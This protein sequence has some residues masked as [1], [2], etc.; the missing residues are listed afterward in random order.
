M[1]KSRSETRI[2][3]V[4]EAELLISFSHRKSGGGLAEREKDRKAEWRWGVGCDEESTVS[5]CAIQGEAISALH[6]FANSVYFILTEEAD[7]G[8]LSFL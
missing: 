7:N 2:I 8:R 5:G 4:N 3:F 1:S 6:L